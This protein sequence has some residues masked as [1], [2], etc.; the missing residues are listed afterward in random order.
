MSEETPKKKFGGKQ[1][2]AGRPKGSVSKLSAQRLLDQIN[3][4]CGKPFEQLVAEGYLDSILN[5]DAKTRQKYET[6]ILGKVIADKTEID[7]TSLGKAFTTV[8]NFVPK[9]SDDWKDS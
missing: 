9:E 2:G 1:E 6:V 3:K 7:H 8:F 4:T 5:G